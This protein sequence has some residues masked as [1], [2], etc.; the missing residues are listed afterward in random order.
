MGGTIL[1]DVDTQVDFIEPGGKLYFEGAEE[2]KPAMAPNLLFKIR[3]IPL[4]CARPQR[5]YRR[6]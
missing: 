5:R 2:A 3:I 1:W 4:Q 6:S